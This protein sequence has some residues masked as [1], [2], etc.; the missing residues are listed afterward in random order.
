MGKRDRPKEDIII[1]GIGAGRWGQLTLQV[2]DILTKARKVYF[3]YHFHPVFEIMKQNG[4]N[5]A[6][7]DYL[8]RIKGITYEQ[9]Y[10]MMAE[11]II[12]DAKSSG[13]V[14]FAVPG[15]PFILEETTSLIMKEAKKEGLSVKVIEGMSFLESMFVE[16]GLDL[17][18]GLQ[19]VN[20]AKLL[21][22][23]KKGIS[24]KMGCIIFSLT[25]PLSSQPTGKGEMV[26]DK[27]RDYLIDV[28]PSQHRVFLVKTAEMP[29]YENKILSC[30]L[31]E[32]NRK[33]R[34][35]NDLTSLYIPAL[36]KEA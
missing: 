32:L 1:V 3:R 19:I 24:P 16:L 6:N 26:F 11:I 5:V 20:L 14:V 35:I 33:K 7:L 4:V 9:V 22:E 23:G 2:Y 17:S 8:Y 27:V 28:Y 25:L 13:N 31:S 34:F 10:S 21:K 18:Q 36:E 12:K 29:P 15:N 30:Q